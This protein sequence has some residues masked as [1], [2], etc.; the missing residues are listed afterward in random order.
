[1]FESDTLSI[2]QLALANLANLSGANLSGA[3]LSGADL[4][5]ADLSNANLSDADLRRADLRRANLSGANLR[6]ANLSDADLRRA[7]LSDADLRR[8]NLSD[9]DL[10][11]ANLSGAKALKNAC[12]YLA[13]FEQDELGLIV[14]KRF[15][16]TEYPQPNGW[17]IG[18]GSFITENPNPD[19]GTLCGCGVNFGSLEWCQKNYTS[20]T[21]WKCRIRFIDLA[22]VVVPFMTDGKARCHRL[23]LLEVVEA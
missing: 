20:A 22:D 3:N 18:P 16:N 4:N 5:N 12:D 14:Y 13:T 19:R 10:S 2:R 7:N 11:G 15:G 9:A 8:A 17:V 1:M 21:L 6:R 23:E